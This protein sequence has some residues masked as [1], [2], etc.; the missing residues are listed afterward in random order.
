MQQIPKTTKF[1]MISYWILTSYIA[2]ESV[3]SSTWD[4]NW[5]NKGFSLHIIDQLGYPP[6][7]LIIKGTATLLSAPVFLLPKMGLLKEWAYFGTFMI[8]I[9]AI[10]SHL[11]VRDPWNSL[12]ILIILLCIT[13]GSWALRPDSR[14][15]IPAIS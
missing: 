6:Y 1:K 12:I 13:I 11:A 2:F 4:F 9:G 14:R 3:L 8:Y 5:L 7:F 15:V 10:A